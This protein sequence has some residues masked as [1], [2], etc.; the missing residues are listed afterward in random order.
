MSY[1]C[2]LDRVLLVDLSAAGRQEDRPR[3][4]AR[5]RRRRPRHRAHRPARHGAVGGAAGGRRRNQMERSGT[6]LSHGSETAAPPNS[7][8]HTLRE[9]FV[10]LKHVQTSRPHPTPSSSLVRSHSRAGLNCKVAR[11]ARVSLKKDDEFLRSWC[12]SHHQRCCFL[13]R[14]A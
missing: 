10:V 9:H 1:P 11:R 5:Q 12:M 13:P 8:F 3:R 4:G 6:R 14:E 2:K 7:H